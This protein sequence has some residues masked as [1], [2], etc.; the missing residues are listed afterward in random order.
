M[1]DGKTIHQAIAKAIPV[2]SLVHPRV[3]EKIVSANDTLLIHGWQRSNALN[4]VHPEKPGHSIKINPFGLRNLHYEH[5]LDGALI[6]H[7]GTDLVFQAGE[8]S[9]RTSGDAHR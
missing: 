6:H 2:G 8:T 1:S 9:L 5:Y 3:N 7:A 4:Y